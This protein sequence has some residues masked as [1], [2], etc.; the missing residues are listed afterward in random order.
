MAD[1][2]D[3]LTPSDQKKLQEL[4]QQL[5]KDKSAVNSSKTS[6]VGKD[7]PPS[8][9]PSGNKGKSTAQPSSRLSKSTQVS[10][11]KGKTG[12]L[13]FVT[14][15]NLLL[16]IA[17]IGAGYWMWLQWQTHNQQQSELFTKQLTEQQDGVRQQQQEITQSIASNQLIEAELG[18]QNQALQSSIQSL[19]EQLQITTNLA[20]TNQNKLAD[21]SGR[22]PADWLLAEADYL[23]RMAGRKLWLEHDVKTAIMMLQSADSRIQDLD[24]PSLLPVRE[25]LAS[26]LQSLQQI[27]QVSTQTIAL[28]LGAMLKQVDN[29]PLAFFKKPEQEAVEQGVTDSID[30]W[31]S[32]LAHNWQTFTQNFFSFKKVETEIKPFM[33]EQQQ[34]LSKEQLKFAILQAQV[35]VLQENSSLYQQS[36]QTAFGLL[37]EYFD[38]EKEPV[39]QFTAS[40]SNLQTTDFE[41]TYPTQFDVAPMLKDVIEQRLDS[42]FTNGSN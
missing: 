39:V 41:R 18:Q 6:S 37:I 2:Q 17:M 29:L 21:V 15:V 28:A 8:S 35:A 10:T 23:V 13:W 4:E 9:K 24:D 38:T 16:L 20:Q 30:D 25:K 22:R 31:R 27:N 5:A 7:T 3:K 14:L 36:L 11:S 33:S 32:N 19:I 42:R 26:D 12:M 1:S 40:L 34:W